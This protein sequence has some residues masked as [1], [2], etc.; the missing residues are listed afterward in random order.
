MSVLRAGT[1]EVNVTPPVGCHLTG[2]GGRWHG[3][4]GVHDDLFAQALVLDDGERRAALVT[5]D[6]LGL[7]SDTVA[8]IR[9]Q[10]RTRLGIPP[11]AVMLNSSHTHSGPSTLSLRFFEP[12][13]E[14]YLDMFVRH[15]VGAIAS[16]CE[17][18]TEVRWGSAR[19][20]VQIG[21]NRRE[22]TLDRGVILGRN[23]LGPIAPYVDVLRID[24][25]NGAP[26]AVLFSHAAH[27]VTQGG[28]NYLISADYPAYARTA[29]KALMGQTLTTLFAQGCCGNIN[30]LEV[31]SPW[32]VTRRLGTILGAAVVKCAE[33]IQTRSGGRLSSLREVIRMPLERQPSVASA[34]ADLAAAKTAL[35]NSLKAQP[36]PAQA[37]NARHTVDLAEGRLQ[38]AMEG[39]RDRTV[40]FELHGIALDD[41]AFFGMPGE[42]FVDYALHIDRLSPFAH[43]FV[44]GYTNGCLGYVPS[45]YAYREGGYEVDSSFRIWRLLRFD[46]SSDALL[47]RAALDLLH[48]LK[49]PAAPPGGDRQCNASSKA[50]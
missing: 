15:T 19:E 26:L 22:M 45:A 49:E 40:D 33:G 7:A 16:A 36:N 1:A 5:A 23:P 42:V 8:E 4:T 17:N 46:P 29:V 48:R 3:S 18:M 12:R 37:R 43:N 30:S 21:V 47:R 38:L 14:G 25:D 2:F 9:R 24:R 35:E 34:Q 41:V 6:N 27:P 28:N 13:D 32:E 31:G 20:P 50:V 39:D 10:V 11:N 44:F